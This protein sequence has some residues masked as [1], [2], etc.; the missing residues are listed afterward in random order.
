[1]H[2]GCVPLGAYVMS[3]IHRLGERIDSEHQPRPDLLNY[4]PYSHSAQ[5]DWLPF[6]Y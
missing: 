1:M 4:L 2:N 5:Q 3:R 6:P